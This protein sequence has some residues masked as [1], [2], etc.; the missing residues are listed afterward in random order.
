MSTI[1]RESVYS[2]HSRVYTLLDYNVHKGI[3]KQHEF[4]QQ[5]ILADN[6]LTN[7]EKTEVIRLL[8]KDYDR[9]KIIYNSGTKRIC[10]N[11][12]QECLT[13]F[14]EICMCSKSSENKNFKLGI[15][16]LL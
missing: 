9:N 3:H 12:N 11:C 8:N 7:D 4:L 16:K 5:T 6:S 1:R 2:A 14:C 13:T 10:E 15:W